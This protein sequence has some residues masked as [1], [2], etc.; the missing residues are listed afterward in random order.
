[1]DDAIH[2]CEVVVPHKVAAWHHGDIRHQVLGQHEG[3]QAAH[4][5]EVARVVPQCPLLDHALHAVC[6]CRRCELGDLEDGVHDAIAGGMGIVARS[7]SGLAP[8]DEIPRGTVVNDGF[9]GIKNPAE[10]IRLSGV[11]HCPCGV[12]Q[13]AH[14]RCHGGEQTAAVA[15]GVGVDAVLNEGAIDIKAIASGGI[16]EEVADGIACGREFGGILDDGTPYGDDA[17][18]PHAIGSSERPGGA[19][20]C[21]GGGG[22]GEFFHRAHEVAHLGGTELIV[23]QDGYVGELNR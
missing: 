20:R 8:T 3:G 12:G 17:D 23:E 7:A 14:D 1:M 4:R 6:I 10:E 9:K 19:A 21:L 22:G 18:L 5:H 15:C 2:F 11:G 16:D 13:P